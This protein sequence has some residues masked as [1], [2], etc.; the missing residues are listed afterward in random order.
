MS[1]T[2]HFLELF[3]ADDGW[4]GMIV[5]QSTGVEIYTTAWHVNQ[6]RCIRAAN[7]WYDAQG[8]ANAG[9]KADLCNIET[10]EGRKQ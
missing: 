10:D 4:Y 7:V 5:Q 3:H 8:F 6:D 1:Y 9:E 2:P